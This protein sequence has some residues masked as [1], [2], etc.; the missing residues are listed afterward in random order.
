MFRVVE[1]ENLGVPKEKHLE[2]EHQNS[3]APDKVIE[4][5]ECDTRP[6]ERFKL[7]IIY[8]DMAKITELMDLVIV[9]RVPK[10]RRRNHKITGETH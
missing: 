7:A 4:H 3:H 5:P 10:G 9:H 2:V 8:L 1:C 6:E